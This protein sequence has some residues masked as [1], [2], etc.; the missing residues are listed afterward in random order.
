MLLASLSNATRVPSAAITGARAEPLPMALASG[1]S[2]WFSS[3]L[4]PVS[5]SN[6]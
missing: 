1:V 6:R 5:L 3:L 4:K 2:F